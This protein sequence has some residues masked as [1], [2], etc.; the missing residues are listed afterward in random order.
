M[1]NIMT[2]SKNLNTAEFVMR[3]DTIAMTQVTIEKK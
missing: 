3:R 2:N 1:T